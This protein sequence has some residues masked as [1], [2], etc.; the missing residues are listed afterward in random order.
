M[1]LLTQSETIV[2]LVAGMIT[3]ALYVSL[4]LLGSGWWGTIGWLFAVGNVLVAIGIMCE[5]AEGRDPLSGDEGDDIQRRLRILRGN[6]AIVVLRPRS[7]RLRR[8]L[9]AA[10]V[11]YESVQD[12]LI[13]A[14]ITL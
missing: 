9:L 6:F 7:S 13:S 4:A 5:I 8:E 1:S 11:V 10:L 14:K 12:C 2:F 3:E